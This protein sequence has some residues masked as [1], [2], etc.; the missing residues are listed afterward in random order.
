[1]QKK[2]A[3]IFISSAIY[4]YAYVYDAHD[5]VNFLCRENSESK[6]AKNA[7][8][9]CVFR[10]GLHLNSVDIVTRGSLLIY[11]EANIENLEIFNQS[12]IYC[13]F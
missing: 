5:M 10:Y 3:Y 11:L 9:N 12:P 4:Y 8:G 13:Y 2:Y 1:M 6:G 7:C